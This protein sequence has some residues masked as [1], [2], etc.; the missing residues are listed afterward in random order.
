MAKFSSRYAKRGFR[1]AAMSALD[2]RIEVGLGGLEGARPKMETTLE[3]TDDM[4]M[5][6][7]FVRVRRA[8]RERQ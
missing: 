4:E 3:E 2:G 5:F 6:D 1:A 8:R 7:C